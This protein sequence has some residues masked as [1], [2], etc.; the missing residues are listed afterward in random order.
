[1]LDTVKTIGDSEL[2]VATQCV[3]AH[4]IVKI[5]KK[6]NDRAKKS[7]LANILLKINVKLGGTTKVMETTKG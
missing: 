3:Q 4:T 6:N 5:N 1:M 7:T 2:K